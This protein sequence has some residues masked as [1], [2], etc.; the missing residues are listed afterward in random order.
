MRL[1]HTSGTSVTTRSHHWSLISL[2][3]LQVFKQCV[4][5]VVMVIFI[6]SIDIL[7]VFCHHK[8]GWL[9]QVYLGGKKTNY[10]II[11]RLT[12]FVSPWMWY[13][14]M[15]DDAAFYQVNAKKAYLWYASTWRSCKSRRN[16]YFWLK[17]KHGFSNFGPLDTKYFD[18]PS[19]FSP[20][21]LELVFNAFIQVSFLT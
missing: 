16:F 3:A 18:W 9:M 21:I 10:E 15:F 13:F 19:S 8:R 4:I 12:F 14:E 20:K 2:M 6:I 11:L 1:Y 5:Y 17:S 7:W